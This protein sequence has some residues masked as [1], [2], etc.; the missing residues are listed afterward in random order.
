[1]IKKGNQVEVLCGKDK[2]KKGEVIEIY[3][4]KNRAKVKGINIIKKHTKTTK[5]K[6]G[7]IITKENFIHISNLKSL[8][9]E[10]KKTKE[11]KKWYQD[12]KNNTIN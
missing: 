11:A 7:G 6:K 2:G 3:R 9:D 4:E 10:N 8:D 1:M 5:E 12:L